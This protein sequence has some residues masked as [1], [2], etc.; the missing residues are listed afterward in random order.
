MKYYLSFDIGGTQIKFAV[1]TELGD[2]IEKS[3]IATSSHGDQIITDIVA[4][5]TKLAEKYSLQGVAFSMPGFVD[6]ETGF[7]KTAGA[8]T[9]FFG[10][11]FK[12]IMS[13]KLNLPVELDNDVNCVALAEKWLGNAQYSNDFI[14]ITIGTGV[15]GAI[16]VNGDLVRGH[17]YMAGEFGYMLSN[18]IFKEV[19]KQKS[20]MSYTASVREGLIANYSNQSQQQNELTGVDIY[21]LADQGDYIAQQVINE[22]YQNIAMG[23]YNLTFM[24]NPEKILIGG[25]ISARD[26]IFPAINKKLQEIFNGHSLINKFLVSDFVRIESTYF[27][28]DSG[29]IGALYH[30]LRMNKQAL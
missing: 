16:C 2:I 8:I 4:V 29:L 13:E 24:L 30:F 5:K 3:K 28:N 9:D 22:F 10:I 17:G 1:L 23:L 25:A 27:N 21:N 7:L 20:S 12:D 11:N 26:E 19:D 14:C 18:N 15:G 6:V